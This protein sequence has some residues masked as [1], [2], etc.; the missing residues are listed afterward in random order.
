MN[1]DQFNEQLHSCFFLF[2]DYCTKDIVLYIC[3]LILNMDRI[4]M[5]RKKEKMKDKK[6]LKMIY[7]AILLIHQKNA[8]RRSRLNTVVFGGISPFLDRNA[9]K[10][11][12]V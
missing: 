6:N 3:M 5:R 4:A 7:S 2:L 8:N 11:S 12:K 10:G 9:Q 1:L